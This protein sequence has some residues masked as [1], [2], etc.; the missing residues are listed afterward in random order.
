MTP[1]GLLRVKRRTKSYVVLTLTGAAVLGDYER[2]SRTPSE[3]SGQ[4]EGATVCGGHVLAPLA[5]V[6][7]GHASVTPVFQGAVASAKRVEMRGCLLCGLSPS[8][9]FDNG[10]SLF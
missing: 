4:C 5:T 3:V 7:P 6:C 8:E 9:L 1:H 2:S 10:E